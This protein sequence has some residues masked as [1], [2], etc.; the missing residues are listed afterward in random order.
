MMA[1]GE[2]K[3]KITADTSGAQRALGDLDRALEGLQKT[4]AGAAKAFALVTAAAAGIGYAIKSTL[5]SAGEL[6]DAAET[7][8]MSVPALQTFQKAAGLVGVQADALNMS[9]M[10]LNANI[11]DAL[12]K[13]TGPA[14]DAFDR[15]GIS[16]QIINTMKPEKQFELIL[17]QLSQIPNQAERSALAMD[18]FGKQGPKILL[19]ANNLEEVRKKME[20]MGLIISPEQQA[21][22]DVAGDKLDG[23]IGTID[24]GW[25]KAVASVAPYV[26]ALVDAIDKAIISAGGLDAVLAKIGAT[27]RFAMN[28]LLIMGMVKATQLLVLGIQNAGKAFIVFNALV[29]RSPLFL[30]VGAAAALATYFGVD[31]VGALDKMLGISEGVD[32]AHAQIANK[33]EEIKKQTDATVEGFKGLNKAQLDYL[34]ALDDTIAKKNTEIQFHKDIISLGDE[35]ASI[36]KALNEEDIKASKTKLSLNDEAYV[37]KRKEY[38]ESLRIEASI[39]RQIQ[40]QKEQTQTIS[41]AI[42]SRQNTIEQAHQKRLEF[43]LL[44]EGKTAADIERIRADQFKTDISYQNMARKAMD[45][46]VTDAVNSEIGKYNKLYQLQVQHA[47][48]TEAVQ[49][50]VQSAEQRGYK[51][52]QDQLTAYNA[53]NNELRKQQELDLFNFKKN[54]ADQELQFQMAKIEQILNAEKSGKAAV[55]TD[56]QRLILQKQ[57]DNERQRQITAGRIEWEK[58][59]TA[60]QTAFAIDQGAQMFNALGQ[61]NKKAFDAAKAFNVANA[62]MNTYM[63][64]TKALAMYPPPINLFMMGA[65]ITL[66]LAQ[67]QTI[68]SQQYSGRALGGPVMGGTPYIVG[69][70]GPE[71]FTP[72]TTG[73]ITRNGDLGGSSNVNVNFTIN[74]VD[75]EGIDNLLIERRGTIQQII[76]DAMLEKGQRM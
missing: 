40:L 19:M 7:L 61:H 63:A 36:Q 11:G 9:L 33:A 65:A 2:G 58:K 1:V 16:M 26:I 5:D 4:T 49:N 24:T 52:T 34:K 57:G 48:D 32:S 76:S 18:L 50:I 75:A 53:A 55:L 70:S 74:A 22:L 17:K 44:M 66:G 46:N 41:Q 54:L 43:E 39:K 20:K 64:A 45:L 15:L 6:F 47:K 8:G 12:M 3:I 73:S 27:L 21:A 10:R 67:V 60:E 25:K 71:L 59:S 28:V 62:I 38:E 42:F 56:E 37:L 23:L 68:R 14:V 51:L 35:E 72:N 31:V 69:E 30:L 29:K 13:G